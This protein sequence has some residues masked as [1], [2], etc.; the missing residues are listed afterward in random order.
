MSILSV[1][2]T[3]DIFIHDGLL[4]T[5]QGMFVVTLIVLSSPTV[6]NVKSVGSTDRL[7]PTC[8]TFI[9]AALLVPILTYTYPVRWLSVIFATVL[10][11]SL[12]SPAFPSSGVTSIHE[13]EVEADH[14]ASDVNFNSYAPP[15]CSYFNVVFSNEAVAL[16]WV[17]LILP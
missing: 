16:L 14:L 12:V 5:S 6:L 13:S 17:K 4:I 2:D 15:V 8:N 11:V 10:I 7:I 9:E 3:S 1:I